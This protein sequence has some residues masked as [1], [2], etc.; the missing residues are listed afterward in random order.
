MSQLGDIQALNAMAPSM[1]FRAS[2]DTSRHT[3]AIILMEVA[4][5]VSYT[6]RNEVESSNITFYIG[7]TVQVLPV[8][9]KT[10]VSAT[11]Y[12]VVYLY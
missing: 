6:V 8:R 12:A 10:A 5:G 9:T 1:D 11:G 7:G 3:K 4:G 2:V